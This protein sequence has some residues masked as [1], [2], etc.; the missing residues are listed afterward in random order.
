MKH[1]KI[2][3]CII[4][5][6]IIALFVIIIVFA[7]HMNYFIGSNNY[8]KE[9]ILEKLTWIPSSSNIIFIEDSH[10]GMHGEGRT[11]ISFHCNNNAYIKFKKR[12]IWSSEPIPENV[13]SLFRSSILLFNIPQ[14]QS[15]LFHTSSLQFSQ[16]NNQTVYL[17]DE[18]RHIIWYVSVTW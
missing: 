1:K 10:G 18:D 16:Q 14:Y 9:D 7:F 8:S 17:C 12:L 4:T 15:P 5:A 13:I 6:L 2:V 3:Q 11:F